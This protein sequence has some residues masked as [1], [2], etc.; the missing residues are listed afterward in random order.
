MAKRTNIRRRGRSWVA[1]YRVD[2]RQ[3]WR[4]FP[5][6]EQAELH[7]AQAQVERAR[8]ELRAPARVTFGEALDEWLRHGEFER[9]LKPSTIRDYRSCVERW[10]R[11]AFG[12]LR[13]D[14]VTASMIERWRA[15]AMARAKKDE[16]LPRR[17]ADKLIAILHGVFERARKA[18]VFP[19]NPADDIERLKV[20]YSGRFDFYSPEEVWALVRAAASEQDGAIF[21]TAAFTGL[22]RGELL[23]L[24][25][26]DLDFAAEAI[27]VE[28]SIDI[29]G[30]RGTPKSGRTRSVPM[31]PAVAQ[32]LARLLTREQH[33]GGDDPVF[34]GESG[35][36]L[37]GSAL[38]RRFKIAQTRAK[39][40][41]LRLHD[42]RHTFGSLAAR[43]AESGR[44][45][46]E[47]MGH[48]DL[49]TT[50]RY[51]H[52][53]SRGGEAARLA[54]AFTLGKPRQAEGDGARGGRHPLMPASGLQ[55]FALRTDAA[56]FRPN[57]DREGV[58]PA[59]VAFRRNPAERDDG[60]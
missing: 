59:R 1:Y 39:L 25:V 45:L 33:T 17:Q 28:G 48:A 53:R 44:E 40:R 6:R 7:L 54:E 47:W 60:P 27:R 20:S 8:G 49:K 18:Y 14:A 36:Y 2:G 37:D 16:R 12:E 43:K 10:L 55:A 51:T 11:P 58:S 21:L 4:S 26:R 24:R 56:G 41:P 15:E 42:M 19:R 29:T 23:A 13:L 46:Q 52:Y 35:G 9:G 3:V 22:R 30:E 32:T 31:V 38:R 57:A 34:V 5:T 50:A